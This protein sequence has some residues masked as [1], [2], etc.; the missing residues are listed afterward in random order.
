MKYL[1]NVST[2]K[3]DKDK[4]TGCGRCVEVCPRQVIIMGDKK[5]YIVDRDLC[6]ECGACQRNC[7]YGAL[8]VKSGVGCA[9]ALFNAMITGG[10]PVCG[11]E[12]SPQ[13]SSGGC[14]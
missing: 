9:Q 8:I 5:A 3:L 4:C 6:I 13:K 1:S 14:C 2:L 11:C 7:A 10:E 12:T